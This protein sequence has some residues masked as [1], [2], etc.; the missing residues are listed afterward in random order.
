M[1]VMSIIVKN[2]HGEIE[3]IPFLL[4]NM[5]LVCKILRCA[6][7][8]PQFGTYWYPGIY[9]DGYIV[10][11]FPVRSLVRLFMEFVSKFCVN[12]SQAVYISATTY[13]KAFIFG[14]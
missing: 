12:V 6:L 8:E 9:A 2:I 10:F 1:I 3:N 5:H 13:Q 7:E 14:P 11:A 4:T